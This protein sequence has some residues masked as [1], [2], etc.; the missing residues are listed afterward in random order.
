[1][2]LLLTW[3]N[4]YTLRYCPITLI[5]TVF[6]AGT[7]YLLTAMQ[8]SSGIRIA[9][10]ELRHSLDQ[11]T[12]VLQYLQEIGVSWKCAT[13]ISGIL[14]SL[15]DEQVRPLLIRKTIPIAAAGLHISGD[16]GDDE[17]ENG[18]TLSRS[19]S[20]SSH[21][22]KRSSITKKYRHHLNHPRT[23]SSG[24][25]LSTSPTHILTSPTSPTQVSPFQAQ[26][27]NSPTFTISSAQQTSSTYAA[28]SAPIAIQSHPRSTPSFSSSPSSFP[29]PRGLQPSST[30][31]GSPIPSPGSSP[32]F[33][34]NYSQSFSHRGIQ[35]HSQPSSNYTDDLFSGNGSGSGEDVGHAFGGQGSFLT[36]NF[37][38]SSNQP[39]NY[40]GGCLGM[41]GGQ[42]L[43]E[44]PFV[45]AFSEGDTHNLHFP[46]SSQ[47]LFGTS[48]VNRGG[49]HVPS[50]SHGDNDNMD[51]DNVPW[52][53]YFVHNTGWSF[54]I[55]L[56]PR[57]SPSLY[58]ST[59]VLS[60]LRNASAGSIILVTSLF[61]PFLLSWQVHAPNPPPPPLPILQC[62]TYHL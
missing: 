37:Q 20:K 28:P 12:L 18:S 13:N 40:A 60:S 62:F 32:I 48:F 23:K 11:E 45:G 55:N 46:Y 29:D 53:Q 26:A 16:N 1:M 47:A 61:D 52:E 56:R 44:A 30:H 19:S 9:Q 8:A 3:R 43:S 7:V 5:Q 41:L 33:T 58:F 57:Q 17:G 21:I 24:S 22:G 34:T 38:L 15:V 4:L 6:S 36:Y 49:E 14:R 50:S 25:S 54:F 51:L 59:I 2:D 10:K 35:D 39:S 27:L 42:T 31:S